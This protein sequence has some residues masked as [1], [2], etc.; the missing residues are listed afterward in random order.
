MKEE[1]MRK[2]LSFISCVSFLLALISCAPTA[3]VTSG[4]GPSIAEAQAE[5]YDGPKARLAVGEFRDKTAKGEGSSGWFG[6]YGFHFKEIGDGMRDMLTTALFNSN[7]YI[8][9]ER[10][11]LDEVLK[12]Q[13]LAAAGRVKKETA[14]PTGEVYGADLIITAAVTEFEGSAKGVGGGTRVLGVTVAGGVKKAHLAIDIRIIDAKTSQIVAAATVQGSATSFGAGGATYI[15][16]T[17]PVALGGF[18]KTPTEQAIRTCIQKAVDYIV[19]KTPAEY[20]RH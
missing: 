11:Q 5:R 14:A 8:V 1:D 12:E 19:T 6:L 3:T 9:L 13:D 2:A 16:G 20:Y 10:E 18:S 4:G 17:L 15:G 7:R